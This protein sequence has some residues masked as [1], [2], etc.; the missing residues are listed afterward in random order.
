MMIER[1]LQA[2]RV[3]TRNELIQQKHTDDKRQR[4]AVHLLRRF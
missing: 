1:Y 3:L 4:N 2:N